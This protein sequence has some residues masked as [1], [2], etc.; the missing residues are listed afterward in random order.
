MEIVGLGVD[1]ADV[2]RVRRL[3]DRYGD[4]F[5]VRCF[6]DGEWAYAH[7]FADPSARLAARFAAKEAVMK[8]LGTGWRRVRWTDVEILSGG[9]PPRVVLFGTALERASLLGVVEVKISITHT[10]HQ[11]LVFAVALAEHPPG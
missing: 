7:R 5:R 9:G 11:A 1:L 6:T 3:L 8:S 10:D 2:A 4:R